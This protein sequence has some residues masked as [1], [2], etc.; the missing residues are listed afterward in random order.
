MPDEIRVFRNVMV[1]LDGSPLAERALATGARLAESAGA[2]LRLVTVK[3]PASTV[4]MPHDGLRAYGSAA[5]FLE[6]S[7]GDYLTAQA[8]A[9]PTTLSRPVETVVL[10]GWAPESLAAYAHARD[11]DL[12]VMTSH[13]R[14]GFSRFWLGSVADELLRRVGCP[15][16]LLRGDATNRDGGF[17]RI[18]IAL[19]GSPPS[20]ALLPPALAIAALYPEAH[21]ILA[22]VVEPPAPL[23]F[24]MA[25]ASPQ[26][27]QRWADEARESATSRLEHL[28]IR[29]GKRG[30]EVEVR[31]VV[32]EGVG[33]RIVELAA[34]TRCDLTV[35]G[36]YGARG[37]ERIVLG[38]VVDKVVR[39]SATAVLVVPLR[40]AAGESRTVAEG[41]SGG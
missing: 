25:G 32:G 17:R 22:Q 19:D 5:E 20:E 11:I 13:G 16:L 14:G 27:I 38:S 6:K 37:L 7:L 10:S 33:E 9:L 12:V 31:V 15:V 4:S 29:L 39:G 21:C 40:H 23:F 28:A 26:V 41:R 2:Q 3:P 30:V 34:E 35:V 8:S 24:R 1:P 18:M 36:T